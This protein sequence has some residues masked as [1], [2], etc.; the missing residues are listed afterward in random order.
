MR[1]G[2]VGVWIRVSLGLLFLLRTAG[3]AS[4]HAGEPPAP[5]DLW[6]A[7]NWE[8]A[9][10][11]GLALIGIFYARGARSLWQRAGA[12]REGLSR[13]VLPFTL[14]WLALFAALVSPLDALSG[15]LFSA[16]MIQHLLLMQVAAPLLVLGF[17][18]AI[19]AWGVP[20]RWR[21]ALRTRDGAFTWARSLWKLVSHPLT[22]WSLHVLALW[23]WHV[24]GLYGAALAD[25]RLHALEHFSFLGSGLLYWG[26][27]LYATRSEQL[28]ARLLSVFTLG[29]QSGLLGALLTFSSQPWYAG[30]SAGAAAW[31]L[32]SLGDQQL[33]GV[34]MWVPGG[35]VTLLA[36]LWLLGARLAAMEREDRAGGRM[37]EGEP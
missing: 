19:L 25:E 1:T 35:A 18:P 11:F 2:K 20:Y 8:P 6:T 15:V 32:T 3:L 9:I 5:H 12:G 13:R 10:L 24:P 17:S 37:V 7:W 14:G 31:G 21:G 26:S 33:A 30:Q 29:L 34:L 4:A 28:G 27:L 36:A 22:A 23:A 16:H